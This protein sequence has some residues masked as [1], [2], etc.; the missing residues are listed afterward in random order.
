MD[1][2]GGRNQMPHQTVE[3]DLDTFPRYKP[4]GTPWTSVRNI[5]S[6]CLISLSLIPFKVLDVYETGLIKE[7]LPFEEGVKNLL[8]QKEILK[9]IFFLGC[10]YHFYQYKQIKVQRSETKG[11]FR[12]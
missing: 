5:F 3:N 9:F 1:W 10:L 6:F 2:G 8:N 11:S 12:N 4:L 7:V